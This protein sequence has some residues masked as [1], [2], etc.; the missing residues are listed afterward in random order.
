MFA[1]R[2]GAVRAQPSHQEANYGRGSKCSFT[3]SQEAPCPP[4]Q[5]L[6]ELTAECETVPG[7][8]M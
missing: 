3:E 7:N 2:P 4:P 5:Q 8:M 1:G 6:A